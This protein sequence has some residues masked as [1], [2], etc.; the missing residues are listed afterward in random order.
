MLATGS[1]TTSGDSLGQQPSDAQN[2][3]VSDLAARLS[4]ATAKLITF[5][6]EMG[7]VTG[8]GAITI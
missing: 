4:G 2:T 1:A 7:L 3:V 5:L 6:H 8:P